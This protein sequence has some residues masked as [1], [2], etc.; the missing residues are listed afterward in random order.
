M[1]RG[2]GFFRQ[3]KCKK[4]S[5]LAK[6]EFVLIRIHVAMMHAWMQLAITVIFI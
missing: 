5:G 4:K 2:G 6:S 1:H 3:P